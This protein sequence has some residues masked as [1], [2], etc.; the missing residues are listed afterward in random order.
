MEFPL[1][2]KKYLERKTKTV[3]MAQINRNAM[4][5]GTAA[6]Q[7]KSSLKRKAKD[8]LTPSPPELSLLQKDNRFCTVQIH[9]VSVA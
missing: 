8:N 9:T 4:P 5:N 6:C 2:R 3:A 7:S 1:K